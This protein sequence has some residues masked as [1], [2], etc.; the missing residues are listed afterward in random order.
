MNTLRSMVRTGCFASAVLASF[1][2]AQ[3][4]PS[5]RITTPGAPGSQVQINQIETSQ[6]PKVVVFATVLKDGQPVHGLT[7]KDFR[8]REDEVDQEPLT[9]VPKL[10]PL[11][12][13]MTLD[14]SGSMKRRL[15]DAQGAAKSFLNTL[16]PQ[17]KV[18]V[19]RFSR[20]VKTI[21]PLGSDR[22]AAAGAIDGTIARGDT[23]LWDALFASL[24]S[25]Q[26]VPGRK[27]IILLSDG[28][29]DD[30]TGK[31]L[32][33]KTVTDVL[34][35]ARRVNVPI[36]AIGLGTELDEV[37]LRK[38]ATDSGALYLN[39][40]EPTE[41]KRLYDS[42][43]KQLAGQYTINYTSNLPADGSEHRVQLKVGE[44]TSTKSYLPPARV[45]LTEKPPVRLLPHRSA[46]KPLPAPLFPT[47]R[48]AAIL[49]RPFP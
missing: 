8:V 45:A 24:E 32:S 43:G 6:F 47:R 48:R 37:N 34:A 10:T 21:F 16:E 46:L 27:A 11:S 22:A 35:L 30:G 31:P 4:Q 2:H 9:V 17:D 26:N 28:V 13:V 29:D 42:I 3:D 18:Q 1:V 20:D 23:A 39:A 44:V 41:L 25:L 33:R 12:A 40:T 15:S 5:R 14:T 49:T 19:V 36:Y 7:A 38:V